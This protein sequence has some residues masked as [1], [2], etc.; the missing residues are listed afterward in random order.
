VSF[1]RHKRRDGSWRGFPAPGNRLFEGG[2]LFFRLNS[3]VL[4]LIILACVGGAMVLGVV[5]GR[6][7]RDRSERLREPFGVM[8]A[9]LL[10]FMGLI[11][12]FGLSLAVGRYEDR[13]AAT[14]S[15]ANAIGTAY[16]RA[17]T[18]AEPIRSSSLA[19][20]VTYT[21]TSIRLADSVPDSP[22][23]KSAIA[24]S[25]Q[26][27]RRLWTLAG[28]ALVG[29]P[30][31]SAPRLYVESLN[32]MIDMQTTRASALTNRVP[33]AVLTLEVM[34]AAVALGLLALYLSVARSRPAHRLDRGRAGLVHPAGD[35]RL[36]S[37]IPRG[38][39]RPGHTAGPAASVDDAAARGNGPQQVGRQRV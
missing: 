9:A 2:A 24:D 1:R 34:G 19:L 26:I 36:G 39:P 8:Q 29:A 15:D 7:L 32:D 6:S 12:A 27:Q 28:Q 21:D 35:L 3:W 13:R 4:A 11:L 20:L 10:G 33:S 17:Q 37:S 22:A 38:D 30:V 25:G 18:L 14:V 16:L 5:I 31:A 23:S